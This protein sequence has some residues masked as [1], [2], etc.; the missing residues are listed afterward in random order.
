MLSLLDYNVGKAVGKVSLS[1]Q[2]QF[3]MG[4]EFWL[5]KMFNGTVE[6]EKFWEL[7]IVF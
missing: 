2:M 1:S 6:K 4:L 3:E 7:D 5:T